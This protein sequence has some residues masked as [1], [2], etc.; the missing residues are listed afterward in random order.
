VNREIKQEIY[1]LYK[2]GYSGYA[3]MSILGLTKSVVY[4]I[5]RG[6]EKD[7]GF[8]SRKC[9]TKTLLILRQE[10][11]TYK[12][13]GEITGLHPQSVRTRIIKHEEK[14]RSKGKSSQ[15]GRSR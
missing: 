10:G 13:I 8:F 6:L 4:G 9:P 1:D 14:M 15:F 2:Q 5:L 12:E 7:A 3:I 11:K